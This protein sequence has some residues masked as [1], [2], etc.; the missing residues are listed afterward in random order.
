MQFITLE[1]MYELLETLCESESEVELLQYILEYV[2][3]G[4]W[5]IGAFVYVFMAVLF[6]GITVW[7]FKW[8][9]RFFNMFF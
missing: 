9:Y 6:L 7:L 8:V 5:Y 4:A 1:E 3:M 2:T